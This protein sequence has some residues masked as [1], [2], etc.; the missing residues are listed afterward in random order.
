[1]LRAFLVIMKE[2]TV[3][4]YRIKGNIAYSVNR[5]NLEET[6]DCFNHCYPVSFTSNGW[7]LLE[8][9]STPISC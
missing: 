4:K 3:L 5:G 8:Q 7:V 6:D 9:S 1:M 2:L